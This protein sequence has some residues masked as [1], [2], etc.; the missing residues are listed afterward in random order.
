MKKRFS[1]EVSR[2]Q[3]H[4][5]E[6]VA[7]G[8]EAEARAAFSARKA[9]LPATAAIRLLVDGAPVMLAFGAPVKV[10][11]KRKAPAKK[12]KR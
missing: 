8:D 11:V 4:P 6:L 10:K 7:E 9:R 12:K 2:S 3:Q 5:W 1:V